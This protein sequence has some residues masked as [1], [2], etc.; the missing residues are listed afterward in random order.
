MKTLKT[1]AILALCL[2]IYACE[3]SSEPE[4][5]PEPTADLTINEADTSK[6]TFTTAVLSGS[7]TV[8]NA[9]VTEQGICFD[10][11]SN[12]TTNKNK[13]TVSSSAISVKLENLPANKKFYAKAYAIAGGKTYYSKEISFTTR[14]LAGSFWSFTFL[15]DVNISWVADVNFYA[16]GTT[17]YD[18]PDV[19]GLYLYYGKWSFNKN[20]HYQLD[21]NDTVGY[22]LTGNFTSD[23][24]M[25][26]T[27][28][29]KPNNRNWTAV[30]K[31]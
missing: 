29:F 18:E 15:H 19:P 6:I 20:L 2:S 5:E 23:T 8:K 26:G 11:I 13:K 3:K 9:D 17:K 10:T 31:K 21:N 25:A 27:Y 16:N 28:T 24:T 30:L 22:I 1:I 7:A 12:P 14:S 4:P